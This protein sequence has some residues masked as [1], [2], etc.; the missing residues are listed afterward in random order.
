MQSMAP[1]GLRQRLV[2]R[3]SR[4]LRAVAAVAA[5]A[6]SAVLILP[7]V[8]AA[9]G[10]VNPAASSYLARI[11]HVPGG[12]QAKVV[13]GDL[14]LWLR[15]ADPALTVVVLDYQGEPYL[16]FSRRG[17]QVNQNSAMF[18]LNQVPPQTP[19]ASSGPHLAASWAWVSGGH[20]YEWHDGRLH[21]LAAVALAPGATY[22]GRWTV[23]VRVDGAVTAITGGLYYAP[24][25][26]I[27]WF[28]PIL[29]VLACVLAVVRLRRAELDERMARALAAVA[30]A[31]FALAAVGEQLH[32][33][34]VVSVGQLVLLAV[35]LAFVTWGAHRLL[36]RRHS[37]FTFF[38]IAAAALWEGG[39]LIAVLIDGYVLVALPA[40]AARAA[41]TA[42]LAAG[43]GL[44]PLVFAIAER[45]GRPR[46]GARLTEAEV[47]QETE[48]AWEPSA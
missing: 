32:G 36:V 40:A 13:D 5:V 30:L 48:G 15:V 22:V 16:R 19:P 26:S 33:R 38:L 9:H 37:W 7:G 18:Y 6:A 42:C 2:A 41:V 45:S 14:R 28:W 11:A 17:V 35:E 10:P 23:P 4:C 39:S 20:A 8:A 27:V 21:A 1:R 47:E 44:L 3:A 46:R 29:V 31:A 12:V 43:V 34:P 25:P 24:S